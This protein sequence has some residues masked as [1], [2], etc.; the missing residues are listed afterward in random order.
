MIGFGPPRG[1]LSTTAMV[2]FQ[3]DRIQEGLLAMRPYGATPLAGMMADAVT[4]FRQ[5]TSDDEYYVGEKFAPPSD[6]LLNDGCRRAYIIVLSDGEPNLDLRPYCQNL[7]VPDGECPFKHPYEYAED[8]CNGDHTNCDDRTVNNSPPKVQ[9][10]AIGFGLSSDGAVDCDTL[11]E[12][13]FSGAG[14]CVAP[15]TTGLRACCTLARIAQLG[16]TGK[17]WFADDKVALRNAIAAVLDSI[18]AQSTSRTLPT[19]VSAT[20]TQAAQSNAPAVSYE[21]SSALTPEPGELW[22]GNLERKRWACEDDGFG[23]LVAVAKD[24]DPALGDDFVNNVNTDSAAHPRRFLTVIANNGGASESTYSI[25]PNL[26]SD[27]GMG[28]Y[29]SNALVVDGNIAAIAAAMQANPTAMNMGVMPPECSGVDLAAASAADCAQK[30]MTWNTGGLNGGGL[31]DRQDNQ[32]GALYHSTPKVMGTPQALSPDPA[33]AYFQT[34]VSTR[35]LMLYAQ[36]VD[37]QLHGFKVATNDPADTF[38]VDT[39]RNN[40]LFSFIPPHVLPSL[41]SMYPNS[42]QIL[43]DGQIVIRDIPFERDAGQALAGGTAAGAQYRTVLVGSG[44]S[45]GGFYYALDVTDPTAP[46]FLWQVS[47]DST[48]APLFGDVAGVPAIALIGYSSGG[49]F[50]EVAVAVLPGGEGTRIPAVDC[51]RQDADFNHID[52]DTNPQYLPRTRVA[53]WQPGPAR[54]FTIVRL[55]DGRILKTFRMDAATDGPASVDAT[56]VEEVDI[57]AP[58]LGAVPFPNG[59]G[60]VSNRIYLNDQD[61]TIWRLDLSDPNPINWDDDAVSIFFDAY[62]EQGGLNDQPLDGQEIGTMPVIS[63]DSLGNTVVLFSTGD[64][65]DFSSTNLKSRVWSVTEEAVAGGSK[66]FQVESNWVI[67]QN[68]LNP[69]DLE[70]GEKVAGPITVFDEVA[71]FSTFTPPPAS[72]AC[73]VGSGR[74]WGVRFVDTDTSNGNKV[75]DPALN[76]PLN[77]DYKLDLGDDVTPFG[78]AVTEEPACFEAVTVTDDYVG[79]HWV[80]SRSQPPVFKLRFNT[81]VGG[82]ASSGSAVNTSEISINQPRVTVRV[83]SWAS[84][85]E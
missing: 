15:A 43:L 68:A 77:P 37:G 65:E 51:A 48:G 84:I 42:S 34:Q 5:D 10:F 55:D 81:G 60:Q 16:G 76:D 78:V 57:D 18:A 85:V 35:P 75:A 69:E 6:E 66:N 11:V 62:P 23:N 40:E 31:P 67:R 64:Q 56:L 29:G 63:V 9:T 72:D 46:E 8:L 59:T 28:T 58:I 82:S 14:R 70:P 21:F 26:S 44:G 3:N 71:Y 7:G 20:A 47:R 39:Q 12:A 54:S 1:A 45:G 13:D 36:T 30:V 32:I 22:R 52:I 27:D 50:K 19:F 24:V 25:R 61:G 4:F 2:R 17:A 79:Q 83:D 41:L 33:Y 49:T 53:C 74:V 73:T 80:A 38:E